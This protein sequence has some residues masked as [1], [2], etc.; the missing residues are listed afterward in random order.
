MSQHHARIP[1]R[2]LSRWA[3]AVKQRARWRCQRCGKAARLE[4]HH[5]VPLAKG[6]AGLD[7][8][9]GIALCVPCH[10]AVG[11]ESRRRDPAR[12][13]WERLVAELLEL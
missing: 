9:N 10:L 5:R 13:A 8:D 12:V 7:L 1:R 3:Y 4:A 2:A 6:G 11:R